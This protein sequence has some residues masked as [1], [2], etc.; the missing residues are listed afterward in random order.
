MKV[1]AT[2]CKET[3]DDCRVYFGFPT[4][5][6][7]VKN[8]KT[9]FLRKFVEHVNVLRKMCSESAAAELLKLA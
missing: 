5:H 9:A 3:I 7:V 4:I 6:S 1:F 8:R 2:S